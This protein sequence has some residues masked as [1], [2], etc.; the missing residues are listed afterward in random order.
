MIIAC[1]I[2]CKKYCQVKNIESFKGQVMHS[3][4]FRDPSIFKDKNLIM[5]GNKFSGHEICAMALP[6]ASTITL[7]FRSTNML[8]KR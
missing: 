4:E 6:Y 1:G 8:I 5:I 2:F 3:S 7:I